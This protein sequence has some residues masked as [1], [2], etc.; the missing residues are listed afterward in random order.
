MQFFAFYRNGHDVPILLDT[1][2]LHRLDYLYGISHYEEAGMVKISTIILFVL[3]VLAVGA[4]A[5]GYGAVI[6]VLIGNM[7]DSVV[8]LVG[9]VVF[10]VALFLPV[11]KFMA[12]S[13]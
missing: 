9:L 4:V 8:H 2:R 13:A 10:L 12:R 6:N 1:P 3:L 7:L 11:K 5:W